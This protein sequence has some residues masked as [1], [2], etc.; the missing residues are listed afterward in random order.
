MSPR[1][2]GFNVW[3]LKEITPCGRAGFCETTRSCHSA[4]TEKP[5]CVEIWRNH[6]LLWGSFVRNAG[7]GSSRPVTGA[8]LCGNSKKLSVVVWQFCTERRGRAAP[9]GHRILR[10]WEIEEITR[11]GPAVLYG[12][13][14]SCRV[15]RTLTPS[16][17]KFGEITR[18]GFAVLY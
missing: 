2:K 13:T 12:T 9:F 7:A 4:Q 11:G 15:A 18:R 14:M 5:N 17:V 8:D 10:V 1:H 16:C 3:Q 6:P